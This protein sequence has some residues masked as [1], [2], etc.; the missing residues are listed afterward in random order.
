MHIVDFDLIKILP[1][2][3]CFHSRRLEYETISASMEVFE[4]QKWTPRW[5]WP[6]F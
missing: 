6:G 2:I 3:F 4:R 1:V 5:A